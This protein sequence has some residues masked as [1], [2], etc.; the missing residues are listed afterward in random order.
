MLRPLS[1][2]SIRIADHLIEENYPASEIAKTVNWHRTDEGQGALAEL[3]AMAPPS[4]QRN[5]LP[6]NTAD[7]RTEDVRE[8]RENRA[9]GSTPGVAGSQP[10]PPYFHPSSSSLFGAVDDTRGRT[11]SQPPGHSVAMQA[12]MGLSK[13]DLLRLLLKKNN[14]QDFSG[15]PLP[16]GRSVDSRAT[17][18]TRLS[19]GQYPPSSLASSSAGPSRNVD[20]S[21]SKGKER[22]RAAPYSST[23]QASRPRATT[24]KPIHCKHNPPGV[25]DTVTFHGC[26]VTDD[27]MKHGDTKAIKR[28]K[29]RVYRRKHTHEKA[30]K[31]GMTNGQVIKAEQDDRAARKGLTGQSELVKKYKDDRAARKGLADRFE[32]EKRN[33]DALAVR[34][35]LANRFELHEQYLDDLATRNGLPNRSALDKKYRDNRAIREGLAGSSDKKSIKDTRAAH[36][37]GPKAAGVNLEKNQASATMLTKQGARENEIPHLRMQDPAFPEPSFSGVNRRQRTPSPGA[38]GLTQRFRVGE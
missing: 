38:G 14:P 7:Y 23:S 35:G 11:P 32:L 33:K 31:L 16:S 30:E 26:N 28:A 4:W 17:H 29:D 9:S 13:D 15:P 22:E 12:A 8:Y 27:E 19:G 3:G 1:R 20:S 36:Q 25:I 37:V 5:Y 21:S 2:D 34:K 10:A 18:S 6:D 24:V